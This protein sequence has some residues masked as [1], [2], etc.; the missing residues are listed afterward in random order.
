MASLASRSRCVR[1]SHRRTYRS[2]TRGWVAGAGCEIT[3][4]STDVHLHPLHFRDETHPPPSVFPLA[5]CLRAPSAPASCHEPQDCVQ[6]Q[7]VAGDYFLRAGT[8]RFSQRTV[9]AA[10]SEPTGGQS[11]SPPQRGRATLPAVQG[12]A[13]ARGEAVLFTFG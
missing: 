9:D 8:A 7:E 1:A 5:S 12:G 6:Q 4:R 10:V 11:R 2:H 3:S 13:A